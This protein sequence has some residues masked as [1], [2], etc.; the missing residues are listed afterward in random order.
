[1]VQA[2][3][4]TR[5][6]R[7]SPPGTWTTLRENPRPGRPALGSAFPAAA[8][9]HLLPTVTSPLVSFRFGD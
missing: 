6:T 5:Q 7:A 1:M 2:Q 4:S 3:S 9:Q 8:P